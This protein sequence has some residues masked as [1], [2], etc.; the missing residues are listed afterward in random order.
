MWRGLAGRL[1]PRKLSPSCWNH[2]GAVARCTRRDARGR[3]ACR[4]L[5]LSALGWAT[6]TSLCEPPGRSMPRK[7]LPAV[8]EPRQSCCPMYEARY[9]RETRAT[10]PTP[11]GNA[12]GAGRCGGA[13]CSPPSRRRTQVH[14]PAA[15]SPAHQRLRHR[16]DVN[17]RAGP[18][19]A[20]FRPERRASD[21]APVQCKGL[22]D[23]GGKNGE[24]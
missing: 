4:S 24:K 18:P 16:G 8:L 21:V 1:K 5:S 14:A 7:P 23:S 9:A 19:P 6:R 10:G 15:A 3:P 17:R 20:D 13:C 2:A 11:C 22:F 12:L